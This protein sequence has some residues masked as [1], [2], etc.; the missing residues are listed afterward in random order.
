MLSICEYEIGIQYTSLP[1]HSLIG[2][3]SNCLDITLDICLFSIDIGN[4]TPTR[5][6]VSTL[7]ENQISY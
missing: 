2:D 1:T 5:G 7:L 4:R 3:F 6:P